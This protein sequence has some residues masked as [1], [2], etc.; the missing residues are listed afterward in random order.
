MILQLRPHQGLQTSD[1]PTIMFS[2]AGQEDHKRFISRCDKNDYACLCEHYKALALCY[3]Q[4][5]DDP[6]IYGQKGSVES[7]ADSYCRN[8]RVTTTSTRR[9][10]P[11]STSD[12]AKASTSTLDED[13]TDTPTSTLD[14]DKIGTPTSI[15]DEDALTEGN[16]A[17]HAHIATGLLTSTLTLTGLYVYLA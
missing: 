6:V 17:S 10:T 5:L 8:A 9:S 4:C 15:S 12:R 1:V 14:E 3:D 7:A 2:L 11:T 16:S 13:R